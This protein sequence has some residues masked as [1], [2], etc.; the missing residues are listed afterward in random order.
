MIPATFPPTLDSVGKKQEMVHLKLQD[1][2][3]EVANPRPR[4]DREGDEVSGSRSWRVIIEHIEHV[5]AWK[6]ILA[7]YPS[8]VAREKVRLKSVHQ[9]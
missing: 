9:Y 3:G 5:Y 2:V 1:H 7:R 8:L 6:I 4:E